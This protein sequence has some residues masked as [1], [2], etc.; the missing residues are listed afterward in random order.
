M[1]TD[2]PR[3]SIRWSMAGL[4]AAAWLGSCP[5]VAAPAMHAQMLDSL[6]AQ[7]VE[8]A[9]RKSSLSSAR[10]KGE[11]HIRSYAWPE[12]QP[13]ALLSGSLAPPQ[14]FPWRDGGRLHVIVKVSATGSANTAALQAAGL[15]IEIVNERFGLV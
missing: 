13:S 2:G 8:V 11:S 9:N 4:L 1:R 10:R 12:A 3:W 6:R 7:A 5:D 14:E 15:E